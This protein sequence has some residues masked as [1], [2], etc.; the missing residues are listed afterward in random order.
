MATY[1]FSE[2]AIN[3]AIEAAKHTH[4]EQQISTK[5]TSTNLYHIGCMLVSAECM[6]V[7]VENHKVCIKLPLKLGKHC[8]ILPASI[9]DGSVGK[10]C[11]TIC[12]HFGVP[13]GV[14]VT[15]YIDQV[16][17]VSQSFG[18]C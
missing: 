18:K 12:T 13:T 14:K 16:I 15:I 4:E 1:S 11:L 5:D 7:K 17:V 6:K 3:H 8:F 10:A 2:T 9:P